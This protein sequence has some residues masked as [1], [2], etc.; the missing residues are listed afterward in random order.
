MNAPFQTAAAKA[1]SQ[2][3][4]GERF[5][6][7]PN[8]GSDEYTSNLIDERPF[9]RAA[10]GAKMLRGLG[11]LGAAGDVLTRLASVRIINFLRMKW[12]CSACGAQFDE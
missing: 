3:D 2:L 4:D 6:V 1:A 7:C 11:H 12:E 8:C 9:R 10:R 5:T